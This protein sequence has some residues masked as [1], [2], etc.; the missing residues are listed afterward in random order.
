MAEEMD[1]FAI[2]GLTPD[3]TESEIRKAHKKLSLALHPDKN[4]SVAADVAAARFSEMQLAYEVLMDPSAR[5]AASERRKANE[6]RRERRDAFE[7][8]RKKMADELEKREEDERQKRF[9]TVQDERT[10]RQTLE[11]LREEG[12]RLREQHEKQQEAQQQHFQTQTNGHGHKT[13][14]STSVDAPPLGSL[15]HTVKLRF[16]VDLLAEFKTVF[17]GQEANAGRTNTTLGRAL[18]ARFGAV[19][20]IVF[21]EPKVK[22]KEASAHVTFELFD[23]AFDAVEAGSKMK[24][25]GFGLASILHD[26]WIGWSTSEE[27]GRASWLRK[28]RAQAS[29]TVGNPASIAPQASEADILRRLKESAGGHAA[30]TFRNGDTQAA[31]P[32]F[33]FPSS[34]SSNGT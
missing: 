14:P 16:P 31:F 21:R 6:K 3:A 18:S 25:G 12:K 15:D 30:K 27:P 32:S 29:V 11:R 13:Y 22:R 2:M 23:D 9:R 17:E 34:T 20:S 24:A 19:Q 10:R 26:V 7:G 28:R 33:S 1:Y 5:L 4:R 8:K